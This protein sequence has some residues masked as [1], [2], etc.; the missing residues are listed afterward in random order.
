MSI[1]LFLLFGF[2][3]GILARALMPG[4]QRMGIL[5]T[6]GLGVLGSFVGGAVSHLITHQPIL[7]LHTSGLIGSVLG[8]IGVLL[9][10]ALISKR[11]R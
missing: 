1:L 3:V 11:R 7:E 10:A 9:V 5:A 4:D 2:V 8:G 6:V